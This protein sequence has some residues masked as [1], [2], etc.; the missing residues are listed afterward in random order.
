[1]AKIQR[2][3]ENREFM[4]ARLGSSGMGAHVCFFLGIVFTV[5]GIIADAA[6][7]TL[8]L[9]SVSW[10]LLA[11]VTLVVGLMWFFGVGLAWYLITTEAKSKKGE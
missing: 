3:W 6:S 11:I 2:H 10:F 4:K 1:M 7:I 8:G 9:T 5:L